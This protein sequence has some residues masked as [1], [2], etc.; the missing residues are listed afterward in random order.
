MIARLK[1][2]LTRTIRRLNRYVPE[3]AVES[4]ILH[5]ALTIT[6]QFAKARRA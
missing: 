5:A 6:E 3:G 4:I 1:A 2:F